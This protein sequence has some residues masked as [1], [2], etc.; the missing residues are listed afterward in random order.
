LSLEAASANRAT[1]R[2]ANGVCKA[3]EGTDVE[4]LSRVVHEVVSE[5]VGLAA[6]DEFGGYSWLKPMK[7]PRQL[8]GHQADESAVPGAT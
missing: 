2:K 4:M 6:M 8:V 7:R 1:A 3:I 5:K